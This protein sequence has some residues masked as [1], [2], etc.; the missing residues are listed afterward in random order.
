MAVL[1]APRTGLTKRFVSPSSKWQYIG[2]ENW[3]WYMCSDYY[4]QACN[5]D[6]MCS[7]H[8]RYVFTFDVCFRFTGY[9]K[10]LNI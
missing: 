2:L 1:L 10:S 3:F 8:P 4:S 9:I 6:I 5:M 7:A